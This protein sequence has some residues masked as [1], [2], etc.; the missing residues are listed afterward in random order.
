MEKTLIAVAVVEIV[1]LG[2][3]LPVAH[4][5]EADYHHVHLTASNAT[6]AI[7]WYTRYLDCEPMADRSD[8]GDCSGAQVVFESRP[9][10][11]SSQRTGIDHIS[12][13][14]ADLTAK[15]AELE[16]VGVGGS[17]VR[18]QRFPD[19]STLR[20]IP[21]LFKIGFIFR[22]NFYSERF[23]KNLIHTVDAYK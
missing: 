5:A 12:F 7:N 8:G 1:G 14:Y 23:T 4:A 2:G 6:E 18:L 16:A 3:A 11:G 19:G 22:R 20:D 17:G 21:G 9:T 13:S 10:L 15:M